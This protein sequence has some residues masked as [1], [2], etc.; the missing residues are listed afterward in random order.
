MLAERRTL[1]MPLTHCL[2]CDHPISERAH[3][4]PNLECRTHYPRGDTCELCDKRVRR[5]VAAISVRH[6]LTM[7]TSSEHPI[8]AHRECVE[9]F[10]G[11]PATL[12]CPDC[13]LQLAGTDVA[14]TPLRLWSCSSYGIVGGPAC[15]RCGRF[16]V[17]DAL[18]TGGCQQATSIG[19]GL[20]SYSPCKRPLY[21]FQLG[22][23]G[24]GHGDGGYGRHE[25]RH[26][27]ALKARQEKDEK[28]ARSQAESNQAFIVVFLLLLAAAIGVLLIIGGL[29]L[30]I[31]SLIGIGSK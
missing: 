31:G 24:Q 23:N 8:V 13:G 30:R 3:V 22:S 4:C 19:Y 10:Y 21:Q 14:F 28:E 1:A 27:S 25:G 17:L 29:L 11:I 6:V 5:S 18:G 7:D 2:E 26:E 9:R 20:Q 12:V 15:P 16:D